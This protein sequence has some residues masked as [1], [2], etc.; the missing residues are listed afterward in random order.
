ML[1]SR[2]ESAT[3]RI[4]QELE[5]DTV[6]QDIKN[7]RYAEEI[8]KIRSLPADAPKSLK[9]A[10]K[11]RLPAFTGGIFS[12]QDRR[13]ETL[14][15]SQVVILDVDHICDIDDRNAKDPDDIRGLRNDIDGYDTW[16]AQ[17]CYSCFRSPSGDGMK[18]VYVLDREI[19]DPVEYRRIWQYLAAKFEAEFSFKVD[20]ATKD[21]TRLCFYSSDPFL[22]HRPEA[23]L[24]YLDFAHELEVV[25]DVAPVSIELKDSD[26]ARIFV[27]LAQAVQTPHYHNF[28][29][30]CSS[31]SNLGYDNLSI[32]Y[33]TLLENNLGR[34]SKET[35]A[36]LRKK[37]TYMESFMR[38]HNRI[39]LQYIVDVAIS[40]GVDIKKFAPVKSPDKKKSLFNIQPQIKAVIDWMNRHYA[41]FNRGQ[42]VISIPQLEYKRYYDISGGEPTG[43]ADTNK[44]QI[45]KRG[46]F[47]AFMKNRNLK[48]LNEAGEECRHNYFDLWWNSIE[49]RTCDGFICYPSQK[50]QKNMINA[51]TGFNVNPARLESVVAEDEANG[52]ELKCEPVLDFIYEI[53]CSKDDNAFDFVIN[54]MAE[55]IQN[56]T[57]QKPGVA[58]VLRS[59][60]MGTGKGTFVTI[61][62]DLIGP[63]H[64]VEMKDTDNILSSFNSMMENMLFVALDELYVNDKKS[65]RALQSIITEPTINI[66]RKFLDAYDNDSSTRILIN[67]NDEHAINIKPD[68]RRFFV[69][70]VA[71]Y[72]RDDVRYWTELR[73]CMSNGGKESLYNYLLNRP[74]VTREMLLTRKNRNSATLSQARQSFD[75]Y[76]HWLVS[77]LERQF[78][79]ADTDIMPPRRQ[80]LF[81]EATTALSIRELYSDYKWM[82]KGD[83]YPYNIET[84]TRKLTDMGLISQPSRSLD[85]LAG[86]VITRYRF[87]ALNEIAERNPLHQPFG[88]ENIHDNDYHREEY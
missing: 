67:S 35:A 79:F 62:R 47:Q 43:T 48:Y 39:P 78:I 72:R 74:K 19:S 57:P 36:S 68:D 37:Q 76:D 59:T 55:M 44:I 34:L 63:V 87:M 28:R 41:V 29:D 53:I 61:I 22:F 30:L 3:G 21:I 32:F 69:V 73:A 5:L 8:R 15:Y 25:D 45:T 71:P 7:G 16:I 51:W 64:S 65:T 50:V 40:Q 66:Q 18:F 81:A 12:T 86:S 10:L 60:G 20:N 82:N 70:D 38:E 26:Q 6:L 31:A 33:D 52:P 49:R 84:F 80:R 23:V 27:G 2:T 24:R 42:G 56:P 75:S 54:W 4:S 13:Q 46:D 9:N 88:W 83:R 1:V 11:K 58:L 77:I 17:S 14:K 85:K